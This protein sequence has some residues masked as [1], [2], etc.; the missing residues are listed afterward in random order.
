MLKKYTLYVLFGLTVFSACF[1]IYMKWFQSPFYF[2]KPTGP[3]AVG[4]CMF[5]W[6]DTS[7]KEIWAHDPAHPYRELM[8]KMWY[9]T[10]GLFDS[11]PRTAYAPDRIHY[12]QVTHPTVNFLGLL[13]RPMYVY[14]YPQEKFAAEPVRYPVIVFS[15]GGGGRYDSNSIQCEELASNGYIVFGI[16][17]TFE[18][19][20]VQ[21]PDGRI[22]TMVDASVGKNFIERRKQNDQGIMEEG[23]PDVTFVLNQIENLAHDEKSPFYGRFD[24]DHIGMLG[25]SRGGAIAVQMCRMDKRV[26]A[27]VDMDGSLF[28]TDAIKPFEKPCMFILAGETI[29]LF[30]SI[31][32]QIL[33]KTFAL[34]SPQEE[35]MVRDRY[36]LGIKNIT[37]YSSSKHTLV[38]KGAG[39]ADLTD[40]AVLIK[41]AFPACLR[42]FCKMAFSNR[43]LGLGSTAGYRV[44]EIV[45]AYLVN[46][47]DKYLKG[48]SSL[49]LDGD[50]KCYQEV[51]RRYHV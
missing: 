45:N 10:H 8:V 6:V 15:P 43:R 49:L 37:A 44:T 4:T 39:H 36:I 29:K 50:D 35:Q 22:K 13:S 51:E 3:Y 42:P 47:F 32:S 9:P 48:K 24:L 40:L 2:P 7:R 28:G 20:V 31:D 16:S 11:L 12:L 21:F 14:E 19:H 26:K 5:H 46:F 25:Q 23:V 1:V 33:W 18:S 41:Y 30:E 27:G 34:S 38:I 17:H